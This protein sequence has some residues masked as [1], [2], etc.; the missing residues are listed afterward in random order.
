MQYQNLSLDSEHKTLSMTAGVE[1]EAFDSFADPLCRALDA[2]VLE[3][4]WGADRHQWLLDF[5]GSLLWLNY[6][7][8]GEVCWLSCQSEQDWEV[9]VYL[10]HLLESQA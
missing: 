1:F 5:E 4:Q 3:R 8:Y 6:E 2:K 9:L 7:F 10:K